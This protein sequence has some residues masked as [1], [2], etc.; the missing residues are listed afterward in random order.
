MNDRGRQID[1]ERLET[2]TLPRPRLRKVPKV[3]DPFNLLLKETQVD[4]DVLLRQKATCIDDPLR[5]WPLP[6]VRKTELERQT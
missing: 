5:M 3:T 2:K 4:Q 6:D 1:K